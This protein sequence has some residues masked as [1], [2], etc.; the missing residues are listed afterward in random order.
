MIKTV[1]NKIDK[2]FSIKFPVKEKYK[3]SIGWRILFFPIY[4]ILILVMEPSFIQ[5]GLI[6]MSWVI[7]NSFTRET[8]WYMNKKI[9]LITGH[10]SLNQEEF[11]KYY[12]L[13][14][15]KFISEGYEFV[16]G[17]ARGCDTIAQNYLFKMKVKYTVY[18]MFDV[19]R[20]NPNNA[21]LV[22][23]FSGDSER[24]LAMHN[25]SSITIGWVR[26]GREKSGTAKNLNRR[27]K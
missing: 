19:P 9:A 3:V 20:N 10:L 22:G 26:E 4:I 6:L 24:D 7:I 17:D 13:S 27:L 14:I 12:K 18:H 21:K 2:V 1:I 23:G 5:L 8:K 25:N 16:V 15:D 11:D